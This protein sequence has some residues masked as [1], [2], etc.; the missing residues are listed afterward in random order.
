[1]QITDARQLTE[2]KEL[3]ETFGKSGRRESLRQDSSKDGKPGQL[4]RWL[5]VG[6]MGQS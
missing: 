5:L 4:W 1:M 6:Y 2:E 3:S